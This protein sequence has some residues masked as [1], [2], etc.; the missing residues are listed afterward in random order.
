MSTT[1]DQNEPQSSVTEQSDAD[2]GVRNAR[3]GWG[4]QRCRMR[5]RIHPV[6]LGT[7]PTAIPNR[8]RAHPQQQRAHIPTSNESQASP[9]NEDARRTYA[10]GILW[11]GS[12]TGARWLR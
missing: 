12:R 1:F 7:R 9:I 8:A 2:A 4:P 5:H 6:A 11:M 10:S 3:G